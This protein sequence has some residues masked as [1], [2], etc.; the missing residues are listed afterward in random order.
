MT[1]TAWLVP[2]PRKLS[3][4]TWAMTPKVS[5]RNEPGTRRLATDRPGASRSGFLLPVAPGTPLEENVAS[6]SSATMVVPLGSE[7]PTL[8]T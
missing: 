6:A 7:A 2:E 8:I 4:P 3:S 1:A 5:S